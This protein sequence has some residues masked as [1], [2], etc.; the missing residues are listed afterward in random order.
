M[1]FFARFSLVGWLQRHSWRWRAFGL[2][3]AAVAEFAAILVQLDSKLDASGPVPGGQTA[4]AAYDAG[5]PLIY[6][7]TPLG[8]IS[9]PAW[10]AALRLHPPGG[11]WNWFALSFDVLWLGIIFAAG[12]ALV[13]GAWG[14]LPRVQ[15]GMRHASAIQAALIGIVAATAWAILSTSAVSNINQAQPTDGATWHIITQPLALIGLLPGVIGFAVQRAFEG[16]GGLS[17]ALTSGPATGV[18]LL[19][20]LALAVALPAALLSLLVLGIIR[21]LARRRAAASLD[22]TIPQEASQE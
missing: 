11:T 14:L 3:A 18:E 6:T 20:V 21:L 1:A 2:A 22:P 4:P 17:I 5:W 15:G 7:H 16:A 13:V 10:Q 8:S 19:A 12:L 9:Y